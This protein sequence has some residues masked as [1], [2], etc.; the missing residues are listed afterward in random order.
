MINKIRYRL[1]YN[2]KHQLNR[3]GQALVQIECLLHRERVYFS[4]NVYLHPTDWDGGQVVNHPLSAQLN[5]FLFDLLIKLQRIEFEF[6]LRG[7]EPS[8]RMMKNAV[9]NHASASAL[10]CDFV[11]AVN[12]HAAT[13]GKHTRAAYET[14]VKIVER[15]KAGTRLEDITLDWLN[16]FVCWQR[17]QNL[18]QSTISGRLKSIRAIINEAIARKLIATDDDPFKHFRIPKIKNREETLTKDEV[19][20]LQRTSRLNDR[21]RHIRDLFVFDCMCGLRFHDLTHLTEMDFQ[22]IKGKKWL[23]LTTHKTGDRA[24]VPIERVFGGEGWK[25]V[26]SYPNVRTFSH[27]GNNATANRTL[28]EVFNIAGI[29]K[30]AHFHL[31]RHTFITLCIEEGIPITTVQLMVAHSKI[32]T[33]RGYAKLGVTSINND[34]RRAFKVPLG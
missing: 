20:K 4:T 25:I 6:V 5:Q 31:A 7:K 3:Y 34:V 16:Q 30:T 15:F 9:T 27:I 22:T 2:R 13:R 21:Q 18:S 33:T 17:E 26:Q 28:K 11:T 12:S 23:I 19:R 1:V 8:L 32:E 14:L 24:S 10:F 29:Q